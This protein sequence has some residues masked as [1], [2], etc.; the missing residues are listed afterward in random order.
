MAYEKQTWVNGDVIT[1]EKMNHMEDGIADAGGGDTDAF[2]INVSRDTDKPWIF[3]SDKSLDEIGTAYIAGKQ[4]EV[5]FE[6]HTYSFGGR[7]QSLG[8]I[9]YRFVSGLLSSAY[10]DETATS[11]TAM[12]GCVIISTDAVKQYMKAV[13]LTF[14]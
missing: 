3:V 8:G 5:V 12:V 13:T 10:S 11:T 6:N 7:E 9:E 2:V 14:S 1:A 4:L